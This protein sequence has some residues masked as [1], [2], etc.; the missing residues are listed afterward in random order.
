MEGADVPAVVRADLE[1][2]LPI[3]S[4]G[5]QERDA[6]LGRRVEDA[7]VVGGPLD[8]QQLLAVDRIDETQIAQA[9][10]IGE[11]GLDVLDPP[12]AD[13]DVGNDDIRARND[14]LEF[15]RHV[16]QVLEDAPRRKLAR[17]HGERRFR[18]NNT[19][20]GCMPDKGS[21]RR[22]ISTAVPI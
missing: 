4:L 16:R 20:I 15:A 18:G 12:A 7:V 3:G 8:A 22:G 17:G 13:P 9:R 1:G 6:D 5:P 19:G 21:S 2:P 11:L 10:T 14:P